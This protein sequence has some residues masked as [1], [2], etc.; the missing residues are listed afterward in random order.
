MKDMMA[1]KGKKLKKLRKNLEDHY[2]DIFRETHFGILPLSK[3]RFVKVCEEKG[4]NPNVFDLNETTGLI[5]NTCM[6]PNCIYY[7]QSM[8]GK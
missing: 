4:I 2:L 7:L 3:E 5:R 1:G 6:S 8:T